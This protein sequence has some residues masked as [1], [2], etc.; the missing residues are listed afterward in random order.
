MKLFIDSANLDEIREVASW[1]ILDGV[2]TNPS[3][4]AREPQSFKEILLEICRLVNGPI[5]A[6]VIATEYAAMLAE[7]RQLARL[8]SNIV[9]KIPL[10]KDGL[11]AIRSCAAEN[12]RI[13]ATLVFSPAQALLA[14][15]AGAYL[16]SPFVGRLDDVGHDGMEVVQQIIDIYDNYDFETQV[17]V[18]SVRHPQHVVRAALMGADIATCPFKVLEQLV[19][20]PLTDVGLKNFLADWQKAK[21]ELESR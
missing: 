11:K 16:V 10:I 8:H 12:I 4:I 20:H 3:L 7:A 15:K 2:T 1:G 19:K 13:N 6:E 5:S 9:V 14:A 17:L 21:K 18:G